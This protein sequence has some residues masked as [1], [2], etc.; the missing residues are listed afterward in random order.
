MAR[1]TEPVPEVGY[2]ANGVVRMKGFHLDGEMHGA[3][4]WYRIFAWFGRSCAGRAL[5]ILASEAK[6]R[7]AVL[8]SARECH[9]RP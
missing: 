9:W 5:V 3:R 2:Y 1:Q 6:R 4:E 7:D 8:L